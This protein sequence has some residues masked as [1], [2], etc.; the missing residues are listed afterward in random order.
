MTRIKDLETPEL[1]KYLKA[2][3]HLYALEPD[4]DEAEFRVRAIEK[5]L[6][7]RNLLG[8]ETKPDKTT[9]FE[10]NILNRLKK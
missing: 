10:R 6:A 4:N 1:K 3:K 8:I 5:A 7:D 2:Y 9:F